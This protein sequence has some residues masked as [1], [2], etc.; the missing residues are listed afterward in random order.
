MLII[1]ITDVSA[2]LHLMISA[3]RANFDDL[4]SIFDVRQDLKD[5]GLND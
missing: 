2:R 5:V 1:T 3:T 4:F